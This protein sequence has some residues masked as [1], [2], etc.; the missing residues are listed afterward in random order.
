[1]VTWPPQ[2]AAIK[3]QGHA[4]PEKAPVTEP[5]SML[6]GPK[7]MVTKQQPVAAIVAATTKVMRPQMEAVT[8]TMSRG[9]SRLSRQN[10]NVAHRPRP[11]QQSNTV[12]WP[13]NDVENVAWPWKGSTHK[14]ELSRGPKEAA[15]TNKKESRG[16]KETSATN[17]NLCAAPTAAPSKR[18]HHMAWKG[19]NDRKSA[20]GPERPLR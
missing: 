10:R 13:R 2:A 15:T 3:R 14:V 19:C 9:G 7:A 17:K 12:A 11:C 18:S 5:Q 8:T 6:R 1:M 16:C 20:H 4:A